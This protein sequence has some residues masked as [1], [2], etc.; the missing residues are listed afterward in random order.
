MARQ[1]K[2][3]VWDWKNLERAPMRTVI[4]VKHRRPYG[5]PSTGCV[6]YKGTITR[7]GVKALHL[8]DI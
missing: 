1:P 6:L 8:V 7:H 5:D 3:R 4:T 2:I